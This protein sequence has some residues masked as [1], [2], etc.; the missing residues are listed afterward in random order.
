MRVAFYGRVSTDDAQDPS[1]SIPRQLGKCDEALAPIGEKVS[2]TFWDV[3]S[4]RKALDERGNGKR[5]WTAEVDVPR[6]GGL[7]E[8][9]ASA[10]AGE[11]D[12]VIVE[13]ID[14]LSRMTA[15][16]TR[17]ERELE[18][19]DVA[20]FAADE[21]LN[22]SATAI[23]TRRVKQGVAEWYVRDL[24]ERSRA[25][26]EESVRQGWHTGGPAPYGYVLEPHPHP[27]PQKA[28][29]GRKKHRLVI[30]PVRGP[31]VLLIFTWYVEDELGLGTICERLN[32]DL[33]RYPP[34]KRNRKDENG[35]P[36]TWS[37]SQLHSLLRN[38]KYTGYNVWGRHDKRRGRPVL[39]PREKWV[40]S[41]TP[42]H[43]AIVPRELF[44][45]V[46]ERAKRN[47]RPARSTTPRHYPQRRRGRPGR[48]YVL[49]GRVRCGLCGRRMEGSHQKGSNWYRCQYARR[50]GDAAAD[51]SGHPRVLG[52]KEDV[53]LDAVRSF[54]SERLFG[55]ERLDLLRDELAEAASDGAWQ[56]RDSRLADLRAEEKQVQQALYRQSLR[57]EEHEDP[58]HPVLKLATQRI[59]ELSGQA[60]AI[61]ATI[62]EL[63]AA[64]PE[65]PRPEEI[66]TILAGI[67]DLRE[68]LAQADGEEL[69]E[70][71]DAF[72]V[73]VSYD[74]PGRTLE[75]SALLANDFVSSPNAK[76]PP[77][78]RSQNS[79][80]AG[81][82]FEPATFGL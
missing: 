60:E 1:L 72:D 20:L 71:L 29:E 76:R 10:K 11:I 19:C 5:D 66:K 43:E 14:R 26:M 58:E 8:I 30:N 77:G 38:P 27:N 79:S 70:L 42:T 25:G 47:G 23:L 73:A 39:R 68:A 17:I 78:G 7:P 40:W 6:L 16:G 51:V 41:A 33:D 37:K 9:L 48:L 36:Q 63:E 80:I 54:M 52:I 45:A 82:G 67:P 62:S 50:R 81:E 13:S 46:E 2:L 53:V 65:E 44:D 64:Q 15:D 18:E 3:E 69:I 22:S 55:P 35:L 59:E 56:E 28:R 75:L 34:P 12:A 24:I 74:K 4:G 61:K 31:I 32:S 57:L 49:R 21:P